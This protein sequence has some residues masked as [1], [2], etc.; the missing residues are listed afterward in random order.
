MKTQTF[1]RVKQSANPTY[2][3]KKKNF[4][5]DI[6]VYL[7]GVFFVSL[8]TFWFLFEGGNKY[9]WIIL[10]PLL[11]SGIQIL[12]RFYKNQIYSFIKRQI[13]KRMVDKYENRI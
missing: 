13:Y 1:E 9:S 12:C 11:I 2:R 7:F 10:I 4:S 3:K 6:P 5:K 8:F